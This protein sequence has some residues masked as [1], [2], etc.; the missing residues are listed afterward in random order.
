MTIALLAAALAWNSQAAAPAGTLKV[1]GAP[2]PECVWAKK[3]KACYPK[4]VQT[5][6]SNKLTGAQSTDP[7]LLVPPG[8][9]AR[10]YSKANLKRDH[11]SAIA[12]KNCQWNN[13]ATL[14]VRFLEGSPTVKRKVEHHARQWARYANLDLEIVESG[15]ADIRISF[16]QGAGSWS[17]IGT[18]GRPAEPEATMNYGWLHDATDDAE[19]QRIV[20][21]EF[22]HALGLGHEQSSPAVNISWNKEAVYAYYKETNGWDR[23]KV[24]F[25]VF[26]RYQY[27]ELDAA[28]P[29]D[30]RSIMQYAIPAE[31]TTDGFSVG[32]NM[33]LSDTDKAFINALYPG[34]PFASIRLRTPA[35]LAARAQGWSYAVAPNS[36]VFAVGRSDAGTLEIR[37]LT[38]ETRYQGVQSYRSEFAPEGDWTFDVAPNRDLI[39]FGKDPKEVRVVAA[40]GGYLKAETRPAP[41]KPRPSSTVAGGTAAELPAGTIRS[42]LGREGELVAV[43]TDSSGVEILVYRP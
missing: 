35:R 2:E 7:S 34:R 40:A 4:A 14:R 29:Y 28:S 12:P 18:C 11:V 26:H 31:L 1:C 20:L 36:D 24:D 25:N 43:K 9:D 16:K 27:S 32:W 13:G 22:G 39:V 15:P 5:M 8:V 33:E 23:E 41:S 17:Y 38:A 42:G 10:S 19:Y 21:H 30:A 37:V 3:G 6:W